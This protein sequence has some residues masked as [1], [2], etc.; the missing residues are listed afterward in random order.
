MCS[1]HHAGPIDTK[2]CARILV[3][4]K[5]PNVLREQGIEASAANEVE[6]FLNK[7]SVVQVCA[8][9][10]PEVATN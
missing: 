10:A 2:T 5:A 6:Q 7:R 4:A 9:I 8:I 3:A 1:I